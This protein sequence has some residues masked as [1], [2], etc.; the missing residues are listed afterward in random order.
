M[1]S[2]EAR[3]TPAPTMPG[4]MIRQIDAGGSG[5]SRISTG[6]STLVGIGGVYASRSVG[7]SLIATALSPCYSVGGTSPLAAGRK[8]SAT[9]TVEAE[10]LALSAARLSN[11]TPSA[12]YAASKMGSSRP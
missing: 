8:P 12:P 5:M 1:N 9:L 10:K 6:G 11:V 3:P 7:V 4:P 2:P